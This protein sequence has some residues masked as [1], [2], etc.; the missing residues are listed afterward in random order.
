MKIKQKSPFFF[1]PMR[2]LVGL[3]TL[4]LFI[5]SAHA[6]I[7]EQNG[8]NYLLA[9]SDDRGMAYIDSMIFFGESTTTHLKARGVLGGGTATQQV[10]HDE[11]GT[12]TLTSKITSELIIYPPTGEH[13]TVTE[14]CRR[15]RPACLVLS[16]GL[17]GI[18]SFA[19]DPEQY[20]FCY[21]KLIDAVQEA[22][23]DTSIILQTVYPV[24]ENNVFKTDAATL[25]RH[26]EEINRLLPT[27]C[28]THENVYI[29]DTAS[30]LRDADGALAAE[31]ATEDG[32]HLTAAAYQ[33]I[34]YYLRTHAKR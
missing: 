6:A 24:R 8:Q 33:N 13:L 32:I 7:T 1:A 26:I 23:P 14:A 31:Y 11:S 10:W 9:L 15:E 5:S 19:K 29:A 28:A 12:R 2:T 27:I 18:L 34:L 17:N 30:V 22:A 21:N 20:V 3:L 25:N 4:C 16:F